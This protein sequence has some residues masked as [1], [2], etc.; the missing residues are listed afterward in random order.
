MINCLHSLHNHA[1]YDEGTL[2]GAKASMV[3]RAVIGIVLSALLAVGFFYANLYFPN[4]YGYSPNT[5]FGLS[6]FI[7]CLTG[8]IGLTVTA[9]KMY[10]AYSNNTPAS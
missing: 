1:P 9:A 4:I 10:E 8:V 2:E 6:V 3:K 7:S 5:I